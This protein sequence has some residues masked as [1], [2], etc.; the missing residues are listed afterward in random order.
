MSEDWMKSRH[1]YTREM[2]AVK[3][4]EQAEA[5]AKALEEVE[6]DRDSKGRQPEKEKQLPTDEEIKSNLR[7]KVCGVLVLS[8]L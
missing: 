1:L 2:A 7:K 6:D 3:Q 4:M 8:P 5:K